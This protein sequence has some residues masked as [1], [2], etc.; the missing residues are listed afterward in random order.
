RSSRS[1]PEFWRSAS[2][3]STVRSPRWKESMQSAVAVEGVWKFYGDYP[4]LR[5][6]SLQ[7]APGACL[8]LIGRNGAGK[9]TLLRIVA[10]FSQPGKGQVRI[11]GQ[12]PREAD[13]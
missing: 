9:T 8:A 3:C 12:G 7:A 5:D 1:L 11:F 13:A 2:F 6:I 4:A 10:G